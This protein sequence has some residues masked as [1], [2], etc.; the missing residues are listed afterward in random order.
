MGIH[1]LSW[2][3]NQAMGQATEESHLIPGKTKRFF[4]PPTHP[5]QFWGPHSLLLSGS[6]KNVLLRVK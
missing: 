5:H 3:S 2:H 6:G 4:C 1:Q